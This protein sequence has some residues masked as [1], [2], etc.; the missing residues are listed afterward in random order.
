MGDFQN[1]LAY[2]S[3]P[4]LEVL[5][6]HKISE[7][8]SLTVLIFFNM[9]SLLFHCH[10]CVLLCR[11]NS[12]QSLEEMRG[13]SVC[14]E[15]QVLTAYDI[16]REIFVKARWIAYLTRLQQP[17]ETVAI[18]FLQNL[19]EDH[20]IVRGGQI[21]VTN[22]VIAKVSRL[23]V[24]GPVWTHKKVRIQDAMAIFRDEG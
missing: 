7:I 16:A 20:S 10:F 12:I 5:W 15:P 8:A 11:I 18:K 1:T 19:Q 14:N 9:H 21:I 13:W 17:H 22:T 6:L 3:I 4:Y 2:V 24:V 23:P